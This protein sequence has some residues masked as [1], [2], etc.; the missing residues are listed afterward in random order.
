MGKPTL[1]GVQLNCRELKVDR[2]SV[3]TDL[4]VSCGNE[5]MLGKAAAAERY[6]G[7]LNREVMN[8]T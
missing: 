8:G 2:S 5:T 1:D 3:H 6:S 7:R 4:P